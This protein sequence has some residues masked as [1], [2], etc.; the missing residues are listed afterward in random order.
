[1]LV[2][3]MIGLFIISLVL[4]TYFPLFSAQGR[5]IDDDDYLINHLDIKNPNLSSFGRIFIEIRKTSNFKGY[6]QPLT[7]ISLMIDSSLGGNSNHLLP[8]TITNIAL[9]IANVLLLFT[10]LY[11][12]FQN[13]YTSALISFIFSV[14]PIFLEIIA[15][16][17]G[18]KT[19]LGS[20]FA[21][22]SIL[23]YIGYEKNKNVKFYFLPL[24]F[25]LST[26]S[27]VVCPWII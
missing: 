16:V 3:S 21:L 24:F 2:F 10:L 7:I 1:M 5:T 15:G 26:T 17:S 18:R 23:F 9:H 19:L 22:F 27:F 11:L 4:L 12:I 25:P 20:L 14:H 13:I 8:Y 6:Y